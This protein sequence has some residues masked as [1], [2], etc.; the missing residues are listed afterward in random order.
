MARLVRLT[1]VVQTGVQLTLAVVSR[2][3]WVTHAQCHL[4]VRLLLG[5][6]SPLKVARAVTAAARAQLDPYRHYRGLQA[7]GVDSVHTAQPEEENT[8][9]ECENRKDG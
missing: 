7:R 2:P 9:D 8:Y 5:R 6:R 1:G 4:E 3:G